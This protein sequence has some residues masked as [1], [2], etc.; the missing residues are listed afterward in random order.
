MIIWIVWRS[1]RPL[2]N[3]LNLRSLR[4]TSANSRWGVSWE[5]RIWKP[6]Y[7]QNN[8]RKGFGIFKLS[9]VSKTKSIYDFM[10]P[11]LDEQLQCIT[12]YHTFIRLRCS[13]F[14]KESV[15]QRRLNMSFTPSEE[16]C[17]FNFRFGR[18]SQ[19]LLQIAQPEPTLPRKS[20]RQLLSTGQ[21]DFHSI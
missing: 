13:S 16:S 6:Q 18:K 17:R 4:E 3:M 10:F 11:D 12:R 20:Y 5:L 1:V 21:E 9:K 8:F 14:Q 7:T 19:R 2:P 15:Q